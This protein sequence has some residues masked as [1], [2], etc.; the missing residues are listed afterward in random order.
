M[1]RLCMLAALL[2]PLPAA[3]VLPLV[4]SPTPA[5]PAAKEEPAE[6]PTALPLPTAEEIAALP[7]EE[8]ERQQGAM[9]HV[10][11]LRQ[12]QA[13]ADNNRMTAE[14]EADS[15]GRAREWECPPVLADILQEL[16][17]DDADAPRRYAL[18]STL[19]QLQY[20]Y[21]IEPQIMVLLVRHTNMTPETAEALAAA[22]PLTHVL[23]TVKDTKPHSAELAAD[24]DVQAKV[25]ADAAE[26]LATVQDAE[27][28]AAALPRMAPLLETADS[29]RLARMILN[30][31]E[32]PETVLTSAAMERLG[33]ADKKLA[34]QMH[35]LHTANWYDCPALHIAVLLLG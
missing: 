29:V 9:K 23:N 2:A 8:R 27:S 5:A 26:L 31:R 28:A 33:A 16:A 18:E 25:L 1:K 13:R 3:A 20:R 21:G 4:P 6:P 35:R 7:A 10:L 30:N 11:L 14:N 32:V 22:L 12:A 24:L 15:A 17:G 34:E 19:E